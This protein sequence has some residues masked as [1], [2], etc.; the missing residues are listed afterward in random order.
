M[1]FSFFLT[2]LVVNALTQSHDE[3]DACLQDTNC[4][5]LDGERTDAI[6]VSTIGRTSATGSETDPLTSVRAAYAQAAAQGKKSIFLTSGTFFETGT[7]PLELVDGV[8]IYGG[9]VHN[10]TTGVWTRP[11]PGNAQTSVLGTVVRFDSATT[12]VRAVQIDVRTVIDS[13]EIRGGNAP[14]SA[15]GVS[16]YGLF[17]KNSDGLVLRNCRI[18]AG[19]AAPGA[20]A[21]DRSDQQTRRDISLPQLGSP[22]CSDDDGLCSKCAQPRGGAGGVTGC[23]TRG[24]NG[25]NSERD[26]KTGDAGIGI[27]GPLDGLP[28]AGV[29]CCYCVVR[30]PCDLNNLKSMCTDSRAHGKHGLDGPTG[31]KGT[32][33]SFT[34]TPDGYQPGTGGRGGLG[35]NGGSG[36]GGGGG[37]G[38]NDKLCSSYGSSGAGGGAGGCGGDGGAGG[39]SGGASIAVYLARSSAKLLGLHL[40]AGNGGA[41]GNG[42]LGQLGSAGQLGANIVFGLGFPSQCRGAEYGDDTS[43]EQDDGTVGGAGGSGGSGGRGGSGGNG[44]G[45]SSIALAFVDGSQ[46]LLVDIVTVTGNGGGD[47]SVVAAYHDGS[48]ALASAAQSLRVAARET[49]NS[50]LGVIAGQTARLEFDVSAQQPLTDSGASFAVRAAFASGVTFRNAEANGVAGECST[51]SAAAGGMCGLTCSVGALRNSS[52]SRIAFEVSLPAATSIESVRSPLCACIEYSSGIVRDSGYCTQ[53][54]YVSTPVVR[55]VD[56]SVNGSFEL[57]GGVTAGTTA[58]LRVTVTNEQPSITAPDPIVDITIEDAAL[59]RPDLLPPRCELVPAATNA[60]PSS[61]DD[62]RLRCVLDTLFAVMPSRTIA[63]PI[64]TVPTALGIKAAARVVPRA[65]D[66]VPTNNDWNQTVTLTRRFDLGVLFEDSAL[67]IGVDARVALTLANKGPSA[68][69]NVTVVVALSTPVTFSANGV[70]VAN[71]TSIAC[72]VT[73][74][75]ATCTLP[76][77]PPGSYLLAVP[78]KLTAEPNGAAT[79]GANATVTTTDNGGGAGFGEIRTSDNT[80]QYSLPLSYALAEV[81]QVVPAVVAV[82]GEVRVRLLGD[83]FFDAPSLKCRVGSAAPRDATYVSATEVTCIV[84]ASPSGEPGAFALSVSNDGTMFSTVVANVSYFRPPTLQVITPSPIN[85][86]IGLDFTISGVG[87]PQTDSYVVRFNNTIVGACTRK[88][89]ATLNCKLS[90]G[91]PAGPKLVAVTIE[92]VNY[93][94]STLVIEVTEMASPSTAIDG[95]G[96]GN[97][98]TG[99]D[100]QIEVPDVSSPA[101]ILSPGIIVAIV[102]GALAILLALAALIWYCVTRRKRG[103]GEK[104]DGGAHAGTSLDYMYSPGFNPDA[105]EGGGATKGGSAAMA[106]AAEASTDESSDLER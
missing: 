50:S 10:S 93:D 11:F 33:G 100:R 35:S 61:V 52:V 4:D 85:Q 8:S 46:P 31:S 20:P 83:R 56:L 44:A 9:F 77:V 96:T 98:P 65:P 24:G 86:R 38:G 104:E 27:G 73:T 16:T 72:Q 94:E 76:L 97:E 88:D 5:G 81:R 26:I 48:R 75:S 74:Q 80:A 43:G 64:L 7:N 67:P 6:F 17:A 53:I 54:G 58:Q 15:R 92:G 29:S 13:I 69:R 34:L 3:P 18:V 21:A 57:S 60:P 1:K 12:A 68:A 23:G 79:V 51:A 66:P 105:K 45:G 102:L 14:V 59:E 84:P 32:L 39:S 70:T 101:G 42:G 82:S 95:T 71:L 36:G 55:A 22:G 40:T 91:Q 49:A 37:G 19:A 90:S 89:S 47:G 41:A 78:A 62:L 30:D 63:V 25:G 2:L 28:G 103:S 106:T 99:S 87:F